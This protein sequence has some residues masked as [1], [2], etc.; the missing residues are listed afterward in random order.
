M[1]R[2]EKMVQMRAATQR[3]APARNLLALKS[4]VNASSQELFVVATAN[5][6][7]ARTT[8]VP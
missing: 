4:T 1:E 6:T 5:A 8:K 2:K 3:A 7:T